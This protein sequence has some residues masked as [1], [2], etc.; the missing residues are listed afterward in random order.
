MMRLGRRQFFASSAAIVL[1]GTAASTRSALGETVATAATYNWP[2]RSIQLAPDPDQLKPPVVTAVRIHKD[3]QWLATAGDDHVVRVFRLSDGM[4]AHRMVKHTDWVRAVDYTPDGATLASGGN[5][6]CIFLWDAI[7]GEWKS[8]LARHEQAIANLRFSNRGLLLASAGFQDSIHLYDLPS[9]KL[10][11]TIK[12]PCRDMRALAF[13]R[14]DAVLATGGRCGTIRLVDTASGQKTRDIAA[15]KLRIRAIAFSPDTQ[16][17][18]S[19]GEDRTIHIQPLDEGAAGYRLD[20]RPVKF[21]SLVFYGPHHLAAAGSDNLVRLWDVKERRELGL[22]AGHTGTV[23]ALDCLGK[24][25]VSAGY[26]T[27]V[28]IWTVADNIADGGE[29]GSR[30]VGGLPM[31]G[32]TKKK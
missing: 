31:G 15:H 29:D 14:D 27:T 22:L 13:S 10:A 32:E 24:M 18:A 30:R 12:A 21:M 5:D 3:A 2:S 6:R 1:A 7:T 20:I 17:L 9:S 25:L 23:A 28:R 11:H 26:D 8:Q 16:F 4:Q 19:T